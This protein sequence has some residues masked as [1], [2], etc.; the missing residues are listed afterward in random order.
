MLSPD[1]R[2]AFFGTLSGSIGEPER[3]GHELGQILRDK[4][5]SDFFK[6]FPA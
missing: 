4:A 1:G 5:G 2:L 6:L 3:I